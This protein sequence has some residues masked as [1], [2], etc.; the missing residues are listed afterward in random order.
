M[1]IP[2]KLYFPHLYD[3]HNTGIINS[4]PKQPKTQEYTKGLHEVQ[5]AYPYK[6]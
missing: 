4:E 6:V 2:Y 5:T 3:V 1:N